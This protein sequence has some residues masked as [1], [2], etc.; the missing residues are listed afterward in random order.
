MSFQ[1]AS[2]PAIGGHVTTIDVVVITRPAL[3][4]TM[5]SLAIVKQSEYSIR[6]RSGSW[7]NGVP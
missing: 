6:S 7:T 5:L 2:V 4:V 3:Q 1:L